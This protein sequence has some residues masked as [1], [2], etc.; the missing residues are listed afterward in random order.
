[1]ISGFASSFVSLPFDNA[2]TKLQ[3][4]K[5]DAKGNYPYNNIFDALAKTVKKEGFSHLWVGYLTFYVRI[6]PHVAITLILQD[7]LT[8]HVKI[9]RKGAH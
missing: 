7:F 1:M 8:E 9:W 4:M 2:K 5:K 3:K 6:A